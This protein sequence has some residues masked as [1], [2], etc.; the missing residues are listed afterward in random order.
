MSAVASRAERLSAAREQIFDA[1]IIG[2]GVNGAC[3]YD[4]LC[5]A[6]YRVALLDRGDFA[7]GT[8]QASAMMVWGGLLYLRCFDL[9]SVYRFSRA[10]DSMIRE[11]NDL[12]SPRVFRYCT[13]PGAALGKYAVLGGLYAYWLIGH[14]NRRHPA[15]EAHYPEERLLAQSAG[16]L[17]YEEAVLNLSDSRFVLHWIAPHTL[18]RGVAVN[19]LAV[20]GGDFDQGEGLWRLR[21]QDRLGTSQI[22]IRGRLVVNCAGV[23]TDQVNAAFAIRSPYKH[24][25]SKGVYISFP[26]PSDHEIPLI[27]ELGAHGDVMTSVP[28]GPVAMW[29]PTETA[30]DDADQGFVT[31]PEDVRFLLDQRNRCLRA[32]SRKEDILALRCGVRPLAVKAD[33]EKDVYPLELSRRFR[34]ATDPQRPWISTYGGKLTGCTLLAGKV[35]AAARPFLPPPPAVVP[36]PRLPGGMPRTR[37]P[38]FEEPVPDPAWCKTQEFCC[39]LEDYL[40]RRTN[41]AQWLPRG[42]LGRHDENLPHLRAVCLAL[43]DGDGEAAE[44]DLACYRARVAEGFDAVLDAA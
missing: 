9:G 30:I 5:R 35:A 40:R 23:W 21:A 7:C 17:T 8:S 24:A 33:Y 6:G 18:P 11:M 39:T 32:D 43:A 37:F 22:E 36:Q 12:I 41:I 3:L 34:I 20:D 2:G 28:W 26:R 4:R 31:A 15:L 42:G 25:F 38:G 14:F 16:S 19:Y 29:G 13:A 27:F 44:A 10:R 1:V